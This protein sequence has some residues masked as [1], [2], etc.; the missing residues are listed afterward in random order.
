M[1][2]N[3]SE[4]YS[5]G[6]GKPHDPTI[7]HPSMRG[8]RWQIDQSYND[9]KSFDKMK[10]DSLLEGPDKLLFNNGKS[11]MYWYEG[12]T[13]FVFVTPSGKNTHIAF[14]RGNGAD[15]HVQVN[16]INLTNYVRNKFP[17][18]VSFLN[19]EE[20]ANVIHYIKPDIIK[21][22]SN[23]KD[24]LL[25]GRMWERDGKNYVSIWNNKSTVDR[26]KGYLNRLMT[27]LN[28]SYDNTLFELPENQNDYKP[29]DQLDVKKEKPDS[30]SKSMNKFMSQIHTLPPGAKKWAMKG[31]SLKEILLNENPDFI[32]IDGT[33]KNELKYYGKYTT[34]VFS[35][36]EN[37]KSDGLNYIIAKIKNKSLYS[38][39]TGD[40][41]LDREINTSKILAANQGMDVIHGNI[42]RPLMNLGILNKV[43]DDDIE[44][45]SKLYIL[46]GRS[47]KKNNT[48]Y[49][50]FWNTLNECKKYRDHIDKILH[51]IGAD[52]SNTFF[53]FIDF[54]KKLMTY[55]ESFLDKKPKES[56]LTPEKVKSLMKVQHVDPRAKKILK[57]LLSGEKHAD[58]IQKTA[59]DMGI[60]VSQLRNM[61]VTGD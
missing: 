23:R 10:E 4:V 5:L 52:R 8:R 51:E 56:G 44:W 24:F 47:W 30:S 14:S 49:M 29:Y 50:S 31:M 27:L 41:S 39:T 34:S 43:E 55:D 1:A 33:I 60:T 25:S 20:L 2:Q 3:K 16:E 57:T 40:P 21:V 38:V 59:S 54:Q 18:F 45:R 13:F 42:A 58:T 6:D 53:E 35:I 15:F 28:I 11:K 36:F 37:L 7:G 46:S 32:K 17:E 22:N 48:N 9:G 19:H 12:T 26:N 61:M